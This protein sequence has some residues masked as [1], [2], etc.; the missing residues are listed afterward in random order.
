MFPLFQFHPACHLVQA[1]IAQSQ[2]SLK[3][4]LSSFTIKCSNTY[5]YCWKKKIRHVVNLS[6][7]INQDGWVHM[8]DVL[9]RSLIYCS[10]LLYIYIICLMQSLKAHGNIIGYKE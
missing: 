7:W 3:E 9:D 8:C 10:P 2:L 4:F 1:L 5:E 6:F